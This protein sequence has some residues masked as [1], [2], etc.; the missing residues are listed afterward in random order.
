MSHPTTKTL[1]KTYAALMV[2]LTLTALAS[3]SPIG[4]WRT[5]ISLVIAATKLTL[6][7][8]FFMQLWYQQG[9]IRFFAMTGFFW[10]AIMGTLTFSDY[11]TRGWLG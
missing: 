6:V 9:L 7:F 2:L 8:L 4:E 3:K 5:P 11:L 1:L 10:L